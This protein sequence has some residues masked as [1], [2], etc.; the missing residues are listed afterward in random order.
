[1]EQGAITRIPAQDRHGRPW[2]LLTLWFASNVQITGLVTGALSIILGLDL[3]W[4]VASILI[5]NLV[6]GLF[7]AY[8][9]VQG[10]KLGIPQMIQSRAQFGFLGAI[11]PVAVVVAMYLGFSVEGG[12]VN[13]QAVHAWLHI[14]YSTA[15]IACNLTMLVVA[16]AGYRLIHAAGRVIS[17]ISAVLFLALF[18]QL[19]MHLP[20]HYTGTSVNPG[21][22][23]LVISIFASWQITWAP[24][25]SDYSRYLPEE[26]PARSTFLWTYLGSAA[27]ASWV[28][29]IGAFAAVVG[30]NALDAD[31]IGFLAHRFPAVS[32]LIIAALL[33]GGIPGSAQ[34][35]YG[36]FLTTL[37]GVSASGRLRSAPLA[38]A[39]FVGGF[40]LVSTVLSI[41][42]NTHVMALFQNVTLFTLYLLAPWTAIN[43]TDYYLVRRG[44][45][46]IEALFERDGRYGLFNRGAVLVYLVSIAV[47]IPFINT[48]V[49]IGPI[50]RHLGA[51]DI[52]W[53]IGLVFGA[54]TYLAHTKLG[55]S[56]PARPQPA[57]PAVL[58]DGGT[59]ARH[60]K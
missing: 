24:Y 37:S 17:V 7:M 19:W 47:E 25:V 32:G 43:L 8:H 41:L 9:S 23:L 51:A 35:P 38:R 14:P 13:G 56:D 20:A 58:V 46:D 52:S 12:V 21:N 5:G 6:G 4:A 45:Y 22:V 18:V 27:G 34:G 50:A 2:H 36:A 11:L 48:T 15:I 30:G 1:M 26:T 49:Y 10:S 28:M 16:A 54:L 40:T 55:S 57:A 42:A 39:L 29:V 59:S 33:I 31:S 60:P 53:I 3:P 44:S